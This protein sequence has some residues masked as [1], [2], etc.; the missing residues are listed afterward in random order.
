MLGL[1][2]LNDVF[3][4]LLIA[5]TSGNQSSQESDKISSIGSECK[6]SSQASTCVYSDDPDRDEENIAFN[7]APFLTR[8]KI[9]LEN[10]IK[11]FSLVLEKIKLDKKQK[12]T[13][14]QFWQKYQE[15]MPNLNRLALLITN[16]PS[17]SA[18]IERFFSVCGIIKNKQRG[19]MKPDLLE[20]RSLLK[21]NL[22]FLEY[23]KNYLKSNI[24]LLYELNN[25]FQK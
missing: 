19:N 15:K 22:N 16:M 6:N 18:F 10:E 17:S 24:D 7:Q 20:M 21:S 4:S 5:K 25:S 3:F 1:E 14:R 12:Y 2:A 13:T 11:E 23:T 8:K 9:E